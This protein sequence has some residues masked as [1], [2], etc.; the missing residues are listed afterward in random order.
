M[1]FISENHHN[2]QG[3][4]SFEKYPREFNKK[5]KDFIRK[6]DNYIC[7][8]CYI[9]E[10][11]LEGLRKKLVIHHIDYN[12]KNCNPNN[13]ITL[14][15]RCNSKVEKYKE[16]WK[17]YFKKIINKFSWHSSIYQYE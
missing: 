2:W 14:C 15:H 4:K 6:R 9:F 12:K 13:L 7:Q 16:Y 8:K 17:I 1:N 5:L 11:N 3:G 10:E